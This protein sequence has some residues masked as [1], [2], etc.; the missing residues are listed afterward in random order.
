[1]LRIHFSDADLARTRLASDVDTMWEIA[2]SLHR[3]QTRSGRWAYAAWYRGALRSLE[4]QRLRPLMRNLLLPV[5]PRAAY[6]PDFLTPANGQEGLAGGLE[7]VLAT[8]ATQVLAETTR[9]ATGGGAVDLRSLAGQEER[10]QLTDALRA[11]YDAVIAPYE[12]EMQRRMDAERLLR[13]RAFMN[14]GIDGLLHSFAPSMRWRPPVLEVINHTGRQDLRLD[15]RGLVLIPSYFC[16]NSPITIADPT[17]PQALIYP[18]LSTFPERPPAPD[19][20]KALTALIGRSRAVML[21]ACAAGAT[22]SELA[23][24]TG[25][26]PGS[27]SFHTRAMREAGLIATQRL[28]GG[29]ALHSLTALGAQLLRGAPREQSW[30]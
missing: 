19:A 20:G 16:W 9:L 17:L 7:A 1:M 10:R 24:H 6:F 18:L 4:E 3:F 23:R 29:A 2:C 15:G 12:D 11:Y 25:L 22:S 28:C 13:A 8:P 27:V 21:H 5:C 26:S 30:A 14:G